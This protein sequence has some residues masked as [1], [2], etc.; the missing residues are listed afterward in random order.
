M[1]RPPEIGSW[2]CLPNTLIK[3]EVNET[4][5]NSVSVILM[6]SAA[7]EKSEVTL[8]A[9]PASWLTLLT[10]LTFVPW[11]PNVA[12]GRSDSEL[13][14]IKEARVR[15]KCSVSILLRNMF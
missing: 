4:S 7:I 5:S 2:F 8:G 6:D 12:R 3:L 9:Y 10:V 15:P 1:V 13:S 14:N 11:K